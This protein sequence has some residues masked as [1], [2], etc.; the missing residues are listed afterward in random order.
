VKIEA[1]EKWNRT[2]FRIVKG[3]RYRFAASGR[4]K[5][6][7][8]ECDANGY[9][10]PELAPFRWLRRYRSADWF[11]LIG[12]IDGHD[13]FPIGTAS[14]W[15]ARRGGELWCYANDVWF[16][17]GNNSGSVELTVHEI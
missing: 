13:A 17:Y 5:D 16:K 12:T 14:T 9:D 11:K 1:A 8:I 2:G 4:W 3:K 10:I 15:T 6:A 7:S